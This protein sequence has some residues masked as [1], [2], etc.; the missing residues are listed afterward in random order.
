MCQACVAADHGDSSDA[1][2]VTGVLDSTGDWGRV[3]HRGLR[4]TRVRGLPKEV[5]RRTVF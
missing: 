4:L 1:V 2:D 3:Q 5:V